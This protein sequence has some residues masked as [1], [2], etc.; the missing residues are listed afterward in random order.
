MVLSRSYD[1]EM[2]RRSSGMAAKPLNGIVLCGF[3]RF[4][5][6]TTLRMRYLQQLQPLL[7]SQA[8]GKLDN[9]K[10]WDGVRNMP[11]LKFKILFVAALYIFLTGCASSQ[12]ESTSAK[13]SMDHSGAGCNISCGMDSVID[14]DPGTGACRCVSRGR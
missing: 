9:T 11:G 1:L 2:V 6:E 14:V 13:A 7:K 8:S 5:P 4:L 10:Y 12:T 3:S